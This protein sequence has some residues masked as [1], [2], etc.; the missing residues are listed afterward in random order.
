MPS[1]DEEHRYGPSVPFRRLDSS[2]DIHRPGLMASEQLWM[3]VDFS[4]AD[5]GQKVCQSLGH[6]CYAAIR[7]E[8]NVICLHGNVC[9]F[10]SQNVMKIDPDC[11]AGSV[12]GIAKQVSPFVFSRWAEALCEG[13][14]L[15]DCGW[16]RKGETA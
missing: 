13:N 6:V 16:A 8:K 2:L 11:H 15:T 3:S 9:C 7:N 10:S 14:T 4:R 1:S 5:C 12:S